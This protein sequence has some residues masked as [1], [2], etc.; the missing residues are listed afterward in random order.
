MS[1]L[2]IIKTELYEY[3]INSGLFLIILT[4]PFK[5]IT[6]LRD[7][8]M[9]LV[10]A[11]WG[12][13]KLRTGRL[14]IRYHDLII[15]FV[16]FIFCIFL[17]LYNCYIFQYTLNKIITTCKFLLLVIIL[18][19]YFDSKQKIIT[20]FKLFIYANIVTI[21]Y[22]TVQFVYFNIDFTLFT[23]ALNT[24]KWLNS[25]RPRTSTYFLFSTIFCY[26]GLFFANTYQQ[27]VSIGLLFICNFFFQIAMNQRA[28][29][30]GTFCGFIL[31]FFINPKLSKKAAIYIMVALLT[32]IG[33]ISS[34]QLKAMFIHE[35]IQ[36]I[37]KFNFH[38]ETKQ[39][40]LI[41][42]FHIIKYAFQYIKQHPFSGVGYGR[43][44]FTKVIKDV[45]KK[46]PHGFNH[47]HNTFINL[48]IWCSFKLVN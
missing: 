47:A 21:I 29:L 23:Q 30:I 42:R 7:I 32:C 41:S 43:K 26:A 15:A 46:A 39:G 20:C 38:D 25:G 24:E 18:I 44:N 16:L 48:I 1:M 31:I 34:T 8:G 37:K 9:T 5:H 4:I 3:L 11:G 10:F 36:Q 35:N 14:T 17:S 19:D 40:S 12:I 28:A 45:G 33:L 22:F 27:K 6:T 2:N 13:F